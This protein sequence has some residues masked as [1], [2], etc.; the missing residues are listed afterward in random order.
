MSQV[1]ALAV[2]SS[3]LVVAFKKNSLICPCERLEVEA[4]A[5]ICRT[6]FPKS[7]FPGR[8]W[9]GIREQFLKYIQE[10]CPIVASRP[11]DMIGQTFFRTM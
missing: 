11:T 5:R 8:G 9:G 2:S 7:L 6:V 3:P 1:L 10:A 4:G